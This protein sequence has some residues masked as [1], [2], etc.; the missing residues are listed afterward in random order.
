MAFSF[1]RLSPRQVEIVQGLAKGES[2][3][4]IAARLGLSTQTIRNQLHHIYS[5]LT[6]NNRVELAALLDS[7]RKSQP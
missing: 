1:A 4:E 6:I 5:L 3:K 2:D 7:A